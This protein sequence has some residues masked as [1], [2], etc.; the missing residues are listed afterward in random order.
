M[1][2]CVLLTPVGKST[3][4]WSLW[5]HVLG[6]YSGKVLRTL[7]TVIEVLTVEVAVGRVPHLSIYLSIYLPMYIS[8]LVLLYLF[9]FSLSFPFPYK[10]NFHVRYAHTATSFANT[11]ELL[12]L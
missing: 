5:F 1:F 11:L 4:L 8:L 6:K 3:F 2:L 12:Q 7:S 10:E 9:I